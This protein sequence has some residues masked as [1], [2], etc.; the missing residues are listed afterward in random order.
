MSHTPLPLLAVLFDMDGVIVRNTIELHLRVWDEF[1]RR[2][3]VQPSDAQLRATNGRRAADIIDEWLGPN[4]PPPR[5]AK[6]VAARETFYQERLRAERLQ[7]VPGLIA[8]LNR[9]RATGIRRA[10]VTS[11]VPLSVDIV[12]GQLKLTGVFD[13][14]VTAADVKE[15]KPHPAPYLTGAARLAVPPERCLVVDDAPT[16]IRAGKAAGGRCLGLT[17]SVEAAELATA[18]ADWI[19]AD[20]TQ[21]PAE[22]Q[23]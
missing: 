12:L 15:G 3:G 11:A 5:L 21:L 10:V 4:L 14:I 18:G 20:F 17:T 16:G 6:L 1:A 2:H 7:P 13:T 23:F 19:A 9:L 22:L 8:F